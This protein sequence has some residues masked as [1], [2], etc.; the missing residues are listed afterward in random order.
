MVGQE[1]SIKSYNGSYIYSLQASELPAVMSGTGESTSNELVIVVAIVACCSLVVFFMLIGALMLIRARRPT[2]RFGN[3]D[4]SKGSSPQVNENTTS[5]TMAPGSKQE[6]NDATSGIVLSIME[7][8]FK[9][10]KSIRSNIS[11]SSYSHFRDD[12]AFDLYICDIDGTPKSGL[13]KSVIPMG[14]DSLS[15]A[16]P[17]V[18]SV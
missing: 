2:R 12:D 17:T 18:T 14:D 13:P 5:D 9:L 8:S 16:R 11:N 4:E 6:S 10:A 1:C 3:F 15:M 7:S